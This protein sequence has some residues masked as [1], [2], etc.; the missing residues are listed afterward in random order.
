MF[1]NYLKTAFR[2]IRRHKGYTFINV[3]GLT[4]GMACC[5]L[6]MLWVFDE[7][8]FDRFHKN[9]KN[10]YRVEQDY[11]YSGETYHVY[12]TPYPMG[13]GIKAEVPEIVEQT[14]YKGLGNVLVKYLDK[15]FFENRARAVDPSFLQMLTYPF[16]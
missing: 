7:L 13:P 3:T 9:A 16:L 2:N 14:R 11:F 12:P 4:L 6:I 5:L 1:K 15:A 10:L 8:S